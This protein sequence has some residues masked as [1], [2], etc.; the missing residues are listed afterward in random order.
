MMTLCHALL[1]L[2]VVLAVEGPVKGLL[3]SVY[4]QIVARRFYSAGVAG[5]GFSAS[6]GTRFVFHPGSFET[7]RKIAAFYP[8][9]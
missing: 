2:N 7:F 8:S 4:S 5:L 6:A 9:F 1:V 3:N